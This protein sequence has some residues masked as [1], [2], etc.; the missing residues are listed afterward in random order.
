MTTYIHDLPGWP[1]FDWDDAALTGALTS[2]RHEQGRLMG[3]LEA[4]G[5]PAQQEAMLSSLT[6]DVQRSSEIE[7]EHFRTDEVRSSVARKLGIDIGG[8]RP[9]SRHIDGVVA[10]LIDATSRYDQPLSAERLFE[11]HRSLFPATPGKQQTIRTGAWRDDA[12]GPMRVISGP[13]GRERV[14]FEAPAAARLDREMRL[15]LD[16]FNTDHRHPDPVLKAGLA[17]FWFVTIHPF[18]DGNGRM[19]RA[20]ADMALARSERSPQR[21]YSMSAQ[22]LRERAT[23]Y[24]RLEHSQRGALDIT[25]WLLWFVACLGRAIDAS[26]VSLGSVVQKAHLFQSMTG[27]PLNER[28]RLVLNRVIDGFQGHL[29]TSKWASLAKCSTDTAL[30]DITDLVEREVLVKNPGRGRGTSYKLA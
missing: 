5:F 2:L 18:D 4:L 29:T 11:W 28:Q 14:H 27:A 21:F 9:P 20:I 23:Y 15:F 13:I 30:R 19:A 8:Y 16:W 22:I 1:A 17:H 6:D 7:G 24:G 12:R 25:P 10:M 26:L 3:R